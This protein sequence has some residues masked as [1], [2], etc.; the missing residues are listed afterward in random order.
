MAP[1]STPPSHPDTAVD[2][3]VFDFDGT[4]VASRFADEAAVAA[5][6][7]A[8]PS[9]APG[10]DVFWR[11]DGEPLV[12]RIDR[13]WPGRAA[14]ILPLFDGQGP[15]R[16]FPG[17]TTLLERLSRRRLAMA[18]VSSRRRAA[19]EKG[20][21]DTGLRDHFRLVVGL[22]DVVRP[23]PSPE[24]LLLAL[25]GLGVEPSGAVFIGDTE[26]DVEAGHRAGVTTWR[27]VW[28]LLAADSVLAHPDG[29]VLLRS[30]DEVSDLL[31][32]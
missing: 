20:L 24:G 4:L 17:V 12:D 18:V 8:D 10:A 22:E 21:A 19:L 15:P 13:A 25:R 32:R 1:H 27:A 3:A 16:V 30:P 9:A 23:K 7:R 6:I 14:A 5:L 29:V 2:A 31:T 11:L 26:L 28:G